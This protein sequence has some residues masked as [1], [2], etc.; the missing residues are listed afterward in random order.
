M[1][2]V[3]DENELLLAEVA[4]LHALLRE[5]GIEPDGNTTRTA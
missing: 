1:T 2:A 5:H 4:R 3:L